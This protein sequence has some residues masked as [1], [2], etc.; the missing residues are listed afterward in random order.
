MEE[1]AEYGGVRMAHGALAVYGAFG[2]A[3]VSLAVFFT[4]VN[5]RHDWPWKAEGGP[6]VRVYLAGEAA[7]VLLGS[8]AAWGLASTD[9]LGPLAAIIVGAGA[10]AIIDSWRRVSPGAPD[11]TPVAEE[12]GA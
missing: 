12:S 10:P 3:L 4:L 9:E 7:R 1:S 11:R 8:G 5:T 6:T 2:G